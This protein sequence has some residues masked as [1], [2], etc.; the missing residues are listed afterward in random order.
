ML[1]QVD[2]YLSDRQC[3]A[4]QATQESFFHVA[5]RSCRSYL[6]PYVPLVRL[7]DTDSL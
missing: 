6:Q 1:E 4:W 5:Q 3:E 2:K 7:Y